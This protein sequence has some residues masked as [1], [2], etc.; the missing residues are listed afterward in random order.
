MSKS[1]KISDKVYEDLR[2]L[3]TARETYSDVIERLVAI[4]EPI[5]TTAKILEGNREDR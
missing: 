4:V 1:I 2:D 5:R 3:Q